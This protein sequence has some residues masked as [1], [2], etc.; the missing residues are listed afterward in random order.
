MPDLNRFDTPLG[1]R[2]IRRSANHLGVERMVRMDGT[3]WEWHSPVVIV[4]V[5]GFLDSVGSTDN[6]VGPF[7]V[8]LPTEANASTMSMNH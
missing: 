3:R 8:A 4:Q 6:E 2:P 5:K 1:T 7:H